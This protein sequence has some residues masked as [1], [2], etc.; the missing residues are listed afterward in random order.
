MAY[1]ITKFRD[2]SDAAG[3]LA[4]GGNDWI[5]L[6]YADVILM[7]AEVYEALGE[8]TKSNPLFG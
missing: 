1:C 4:Y 5:I 6:R 7:M 3:T 8:E 2:T